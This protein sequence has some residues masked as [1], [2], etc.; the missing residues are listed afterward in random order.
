MNVSTGWV[1]LTNAVL[2]AIW[3]EKVLLDPILREGSTLPFIAHCLCWLFSFGSL[4]YSMTYPAGIG[5]LLVGWGWAHVFAYQVPPFQCL[6]CLTGWLTQPSSRGSCSGKRRIH[7]TLTLQ[8]PINADSA[9]IRRARN[10]V[11]RSRGQI[12]SF[13]SLK[14]SESCIAALSCW[15]RCVKTV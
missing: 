6:C 5:T 12:I 11:I 3:S 13:S 10:E 4:L 7:A 8:P 15:L 9:C 1:V 14:L 2:N